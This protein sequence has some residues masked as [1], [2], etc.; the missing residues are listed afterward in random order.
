MAS[1]KVIIIG[2]GIAGPVLG[3]FLQSKG[4]RIVIYERT[5]RDSDAVGVSLMYDRWDFPTQCSTINNI[6]FQAAT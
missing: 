1:T 6:S 4:Y 2:C 5:D 3:A